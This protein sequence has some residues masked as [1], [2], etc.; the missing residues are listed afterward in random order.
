MAKSI[1]ERMKDVES[2]IPQLD[3][4]QTENAQDLLR[5]I[6]HLAL[7]HNELIRRICFVTHEPAYKFDDL[8]VN[9][10]EAIERPEETGRT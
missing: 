10:N 3:A 6:G 7:A 4:A 1:Y 9:I 8:I 5:M 2:W